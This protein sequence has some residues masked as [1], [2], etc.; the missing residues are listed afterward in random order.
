MLD[1]ESDITLWPLSSLRLELD[2]EGTGSLSAGVGGRSI[3]G[4]VAE[5]EISESLQLLN[6][7]STGGGARADKGIHKNI[8]SKYCLSFIEDILSTTYHIE[9]NFILRV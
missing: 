6:I 5:A 4:G 8:V 9:H 1:L 2:S 3:G 7:T